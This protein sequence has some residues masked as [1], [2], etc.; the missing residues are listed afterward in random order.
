[1]RLTR[2]RGHE[3]TQPAAPPRRRP[4][5]PRRR[6]KKWAFCGPLYPLAQ[7]PWWRVEWNTLD[8]PHLCAHWMRP[9]ARAGREIWLEKARKIHGYT[10]YIPWIYVKWYA[11]YIYGYTRYILSRYTCIW[12]R[13]LLLYHRFLWYH[14][15]SKLLWYH[16]ISYVISCVWYNKYDIAYDII[17]K[18]MI[19]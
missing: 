13:A 14:T 11:M 12:N 10:T 15:S 17:V 16:N 7:L 1:M 5:A 2:T 9:A 8:Y 18:T 3:A 6:K 4:A 19:S